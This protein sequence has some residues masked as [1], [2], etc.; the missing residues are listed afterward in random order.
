MTAAAPL[1]EVSTCY[2]SGAY[3]LF[4]DMAAAVSALA[5]ALGS[6]TAASRL[7]YTLGRAGLA[8]RLAA[9]RVRDDAPGPP[10]G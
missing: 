6:T 3:G 10:S 9:L 8:S 5:C 1:D 4:L 2:I 7:L